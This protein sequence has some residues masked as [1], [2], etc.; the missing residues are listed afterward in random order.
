MF[1][2]IVWFLFFG[3]MLVYIEDR[4]WVKIWFE[5]VVRLHYSTFA[6]KQ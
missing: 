6:T 5:I 1:A 4:Q 2:D 3:S